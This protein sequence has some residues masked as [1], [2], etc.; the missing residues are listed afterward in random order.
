MWMHSP[1]P[2]LLRI[3]TST[4]VVTFRSTRTHQV[5]AMCSASFAVAWDWSFSHGL[6][7]WDR[8]VCCPS[9]VFSMHVHARIHRA[10]LLASLS[11]VL[12]PGDN[13][14]GANPPCSSSSSQ[15]RLNAVARLR[16]SDV[17]S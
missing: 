6:A 12:V 10:S 16:V 9:A 15:E 8:R 13:V 1:S 2:L 11:F 3:V 7:R 5:C 14:P 17:M 4:V